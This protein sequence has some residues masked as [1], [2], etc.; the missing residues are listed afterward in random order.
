MVE[1]GNRGHEG[2][3]GVSVSL[4]VVYLLQSSTTFWD[5]TTFW[6]ISQL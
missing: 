1:E 4:T 3:M 2:C 5:T 6:E